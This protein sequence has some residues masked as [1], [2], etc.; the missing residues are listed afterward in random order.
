[1]L[2]ALLRDGMERRHSA[3]S[4]RQLQSTIIDMSTRLEENFVLSNEQ[5]VSTVCFPNHLNISLTSTVQANVR[6]IV[7]DTLYEASRTQVMGL[8]FDVEV[9]LYLNIIY[10]SLT[11]IFFSEKIAGRTEEFSPS[12]CL[13]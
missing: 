6:I 8:H 5:K 4:F 3:E 9:C 10:C 1:M 12:D 7:A 11:S 2:G 13:W